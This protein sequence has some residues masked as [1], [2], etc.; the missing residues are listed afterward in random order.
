M[1]D[2]KYVEADIEEQ[3]CRI[4]YFS[5]RKKLPGGEVDFLIS[6]R[7]YVTPPDPAMRYIAQADK[8][9]N[10][11]TAP[12]TPTGWGTTLSVALW[13]CVKAIRRFPYEPLD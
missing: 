13:E 2:W 6:V 10:Q 9:T 7:E 11:K 4:E 8:Q 5:I 1:E 3:F 12:Y